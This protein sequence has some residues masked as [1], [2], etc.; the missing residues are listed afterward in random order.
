MRVFALGLIL[1]LSCAGGAG[2]SAAP[3]ASPI[4]RWV[5]EGGWSQ[6]D[7]YRCGANFCGRIVWLK[8]PRDQ[9]GKIKVDSKNPDP[10]KR[11]HTMVGLTIMWNFASTSDPDEWEGGRIYNPLDGDTYRAK[12]KLRPDGKL[13]VRGYVV[14]P[15]FGGNQHWER[16]K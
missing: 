7:I 14:V 13:E 6:I 16:V 3:N 12:M 11:T 9:H 1:L 10:A 15:L 8:E 5:T 4:G 2:V